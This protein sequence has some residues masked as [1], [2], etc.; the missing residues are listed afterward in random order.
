MRLIDADK[1][2]FFDC[3]AK[4]ENSVC[5]HAKGIVSK[6]G[7]DAQPTVEAIPIEFIKEQMESARY[8]WSNSDKN[9][10]LYWKGVYKGLMALIRN[11]EKEN[12]KETEELYQ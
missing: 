1:I 10:E 6:D 3:L 8:I 2:T 5:C 11:W 12:E 9:V 4:T 7:I